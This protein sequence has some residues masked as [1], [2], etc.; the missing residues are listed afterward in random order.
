M[1]QRKAASGTRALGLSGPILDPLVSVN[2]CTTK[3]QT[4]NQNVSPWL[5]LQPELDQ[6]ADGFW[7]TG[8]VILL[9]TQAVKRSERI[10]GHADVNRRALDEWSTSL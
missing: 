10:C 7:P 5:R 2:Y 9:P 4:I 8:K 3:A 6:A 1:A